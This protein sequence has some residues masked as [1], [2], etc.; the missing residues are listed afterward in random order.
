[1]MPSGA[2]PQDTAEQDG[3]QEMPLHARAVH[4]PGELRSEPNSMLAAPVAAFECQRPM[5]GCGLCRFVTDTVF[6]RLRLSSGRWRGRSAVRG[7][8]TTTACGYARNAT[9]GTSKSATPRG[10]T[11]LSR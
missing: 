10:S 5:K 11:A 4:A 8:Y 7:W 9:P 6:T 3:D 2:P 1:M